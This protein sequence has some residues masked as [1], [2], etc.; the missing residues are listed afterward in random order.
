MSMLRLARSSGRE[1][2]LH[3]VVSV[4]SPDEL[5]YAAE[6]VSAETSVVYSRHAPSRDARAPGRL[7][8]EDLPDDLAPGLVAYVCGTNGFA[9]H[10]TDLLIDRGV[11][12]AAIRVERFGPSG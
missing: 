6:L 4:R 2:L 9:D 11:S 10:A 7:R 12:A 3:L 8:A 1:D 5:L